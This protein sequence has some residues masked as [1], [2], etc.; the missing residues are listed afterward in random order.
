MNYMLAQS[1]P[2]GNLVTFPF[3]LTVLSLMPLIFYTELLR[4][5]GIYHGCMHMVLIHWQEPGFLGEFFQYLGRYLLECSDYLNWKTN[6]FVF[7]NWPDLIWLKRS[8]QESV[9]LET[10]WRLTL[11]VLYY[12]HVQYFLWGSHLAYLWLNIDPTTSFLPPSYP[13]IWFALYMHTS[14]RI[15]THSIPFP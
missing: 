5:Q 13:S 6:L 12:T 15:H 11:F 2:L 4:S 14:T 10:D 1:T 3:S 7:F 8:G 9:W